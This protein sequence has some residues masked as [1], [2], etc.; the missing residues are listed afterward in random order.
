MLLR[1][2][3]DLAVLL[4]FRGSRKAMTVIRASISNGIIPHKCGTLEDVHQLGAVLG[5]SVAVIDVNQ[6]A[7]GGIGRANSER[8][9]A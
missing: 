7:R 9:C 2:V 3:R 4:E 5:G 8:A 6:F 1:A